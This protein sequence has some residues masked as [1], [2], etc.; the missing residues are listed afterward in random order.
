MKTP[1]ESNGAVAARF[2]AA[3]GSRQFAPEVVDAAKKCL[4]DWCGVALGAFHEPA[5]Q[6]VRAM[7]ESWGGSGAAPILLGGRTTPA[8]SAL[9]NG[10][11]AHCL[12]FDD[13]H[14]GSLA[15][16]SGP[17]WAAALALG[18]EH[19]HSGAQALACF[20]TG[21]EVGGRLGGGG[22]GEA[23][24]ERGFHSTGVIGK[25]AAAATACAALGLD[26]A[27]T[28]NA[29][30]LAA[31][32]AGGL[33]GS[34]GTMAKPFHAG[35][36]AMDGVLSAQL[37]ARSFE[38]AT[39]L[40]D[41]EDG[42][43]RAM[44]QDGAVAVAPL[45][46]SAGQELLRNTFKPYASCLLTH[47]AI[48]AARRLAGE[49]NGGE[50][51]RAVLEIHPLA[52]QVAGK[53]APATPLEGKFSL[54]YCVA[55]GLA[56]HGATAADFSAERLAEPA[57]KALVQ[58][59]EVKP[60]PEMDKRAAALDVHLAGGRRLRAEVPMALGNP[61]NP[62]SWQDMEDKFMPL[63]EP[64]LAGNARKLLEALRRFEAPGAFAEALEFLRGE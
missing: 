60:A 30:G 9:V 54:A 44:V 56:G 40:L 39:H 32:Q 2:I 47:P 31:T 49:I 59:L 22:L 23:L 34:F 35:K 14:V 63:V 37:A 52:P 33:T 11:M 20:V 24:T 18:A 25:L 62:M 15:H 58:R 45:E 19:G 10:T 61:D 64:V 48:D 3:A 53:P 43:A 5:A 6:A 21:F 55:L 4:V 38:A 36:S 27:Q 1:H 16:L 17:T 8:L 41:G 57:I 12:D 42:L 13:T 51:E 46:L 28:A 50:V 29:L 26:E 7:A